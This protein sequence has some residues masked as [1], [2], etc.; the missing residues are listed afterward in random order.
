MKGICGKCGFV[1]EMHKVG[2]VFPDI[3]FGIAQCP[4][5]CFLFDFIIERRGSKK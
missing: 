3:R 2:R 4:N 1:G 5:C